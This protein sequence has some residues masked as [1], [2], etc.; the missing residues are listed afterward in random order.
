MM[1]A[2]TITTT[3][4]ATTT[5]TGFMIQSPFFDIDIGGNP[6]F[7]FLLNNSADS[8]CGSSNDGN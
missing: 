7:L 4:M 2:A 8:N 6:L 3:T 5:T 1:M